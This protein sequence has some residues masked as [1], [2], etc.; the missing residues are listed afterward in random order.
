MQMWPLYKS[1]SHLVH[2]RKERYNTK[3]CRQAPTEKCRNQSDVIVVL[4]LLSD[5]SKSL[6]IIQ[7]HPRT[8]LRNASLLVGIVN[9]LFSILLKNSPRIVSTAAKVGIDLF[10]FAV[11]VRVNFGA[12]FAS[13]IDS[14]IWS[15]RLHRC[16]HRC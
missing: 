7:L 6:N 8:H 5:T 2:E 1:S 3:E 9:M 15:R 16:R 14:Q 10:R 12:G 4:H 13:C 11:V